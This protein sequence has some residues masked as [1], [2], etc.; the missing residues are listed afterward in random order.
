MNPSFPVLKVALLGCGVVGSEVA[1]LLTEHADELA[2]RTGARLELAG[3]AVR[4]VGAKRAAGIDT[5]LLTVDASALVNRPDVP[6]IGP[7]NNGRGHAA[8]H[9][10]QR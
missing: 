1:R 5:S 7:S 2:Q 6:S 3:I 4:R 8:P 9:H 10:C